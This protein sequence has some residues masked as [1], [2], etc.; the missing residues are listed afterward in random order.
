[1][2][3]LNGS[4]DAKDDTKGYDVI[5]FF[6][7]DWKSLNDLQPEAI[8]L[9]KRWVSEFSGGVI[10][11][12][13]DV[14][15]PDLA[16]AGD[17][18]DSL[19]PDPHAVSRV[20]KR[21]FLLRFAVGQRFRSALARQNDRCRL[22]RELPASHRQAFGEPRLLGRGVRGLLPLLSHDRGE[23][24]GHGV[25]HLPRHPHGRW[26]RLADFARLANVRFGKDAVPRQRRNLAA[27][28]DLQHLPRTAVDQA[29][30]AKP[31]KAAAAKA[32]AP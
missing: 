2:E 21:E 14:Y 29:A 24:R 22:R 17:A 11:V 32:E 7:P 5:V 13:G 12:A 19:E 16:A 10:F 3:E 20:L 30:S 18:G 4:P 25:C 9:L 1:M 23:I 27:A 8:P 15:T 6:D 31:A 28:G 26:Q